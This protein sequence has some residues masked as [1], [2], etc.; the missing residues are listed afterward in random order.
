MLG[1]G[2]F[3]RHANKFNYTPRYYDPEKEAREQRRAELHGRRDDKN[4]TGEY[5]PGQYIRTKHEARAASRREAAS[6]S[7]GKLMIT[8]VAVVLLML[9]VYLLVPRIMG[10]FETSS[11][12]PVQST[13]AV[14]QEFNPDATIVVVPN[15]YQEPEQ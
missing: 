13:P 3:K 1:F 11:R 15:D 9:V 8:A 10:A 12:Q 2:P 6:N 7:Q 5:T 14:E 4:D